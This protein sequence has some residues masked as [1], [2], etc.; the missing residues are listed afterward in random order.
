MSRK[1]TSVIALGL[2]PVLLGGILRAADSADASD[3]RLRDALRSTMLQLR[4]A[5]SDRASLQAAQAESDQK[6]KLLA[7]QV[8]A[9]ARQSAADK[10]AADKASADF[11]SRISAQ[12]EETARLKEAL[13]KWKT[14]YE[15]AAGVARATDAQRAKLATENLALQRC[16]ADQQTKNAA[17]FK[18]GNEILTRYEKFGLGDAISAK[19]PFV[20]LTRVKLENLVQDYQDQLLDHRIK[21]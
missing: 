9:L 19:E 10:A 2:L 12:A 1:L 6:N 7:E 8:K 4:T 5:E 17:L 18:L 15:Q 21:P 3:A 20:G 14:A 13:E 11:S 16:V